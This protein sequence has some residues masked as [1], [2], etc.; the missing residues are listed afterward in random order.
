M[1]FLLLFSYS[2]LDVWIVIFFF[3]GFAFVLCDLDSLLYHLDICDYPVVLA[4]W[5]PWNDVYEAKRSQ[6]FGV[7]IGHCTDKLRIFTL[8]V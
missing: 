1:L 8:S 4:W 6:F 7:E 2:M 5:M 3:P